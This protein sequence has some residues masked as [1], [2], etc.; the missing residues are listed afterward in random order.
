MFEHLKVAVDNYNNPGWKQEYDAR[1]GRSFIFC[2]VTNLVRRVYE[3]IPQ[4]NELY[5][6]D[7]SASSILQYTSVHKLCGWYSPSRTFC[8]SDEL[9]I[10]LEKQ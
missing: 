2:T 9:E 4:V 1:I 10:T 8:T 6:M 3:R 7:T 5:Y